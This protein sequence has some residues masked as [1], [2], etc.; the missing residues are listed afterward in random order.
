MVRNCSPYRGSRSGNRLHGIVCR[1]GGMASR[2]LDPRSPHAA[3]RL[4]PHEDER[5]LR[6]RV[7]IESDWHE[8]G[9]DGEVTVLGSTPAREGPIPSAQG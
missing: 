7:G 6:I 9:S 1:A 3:G 4:L 8:H 5:R 2:G